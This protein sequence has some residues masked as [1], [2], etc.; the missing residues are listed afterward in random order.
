MRQ[1]HDKSKWQTKFQYPGLLFP[2]LVPASLHSRIVLTS[3]L[4]M[5]NLHVNLSRPWKPGIGSNIILDHSVKV[6]F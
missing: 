2:L 4:V 3:D 5:L 6:F 1:S